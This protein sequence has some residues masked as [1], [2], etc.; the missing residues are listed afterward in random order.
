MNKQAELNI[1][2]RK[3][4]KL[5]DEIKQI[6]YENHRLEMEAIDDI[7]RKF[8][9][10]MRFLQNV[11]I[12]HDEIAFRTMVSFNSINPFV[13]FSEEEISKHRRRF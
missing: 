9:D 8:E 7:G 2:N 1:I 5:K 6:D 4:E 12:A 11:L 3:I 10:E 13:R